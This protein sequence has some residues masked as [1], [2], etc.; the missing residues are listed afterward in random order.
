MKILALLCSFTLA[1]TVA[2]AR[3]QE[4]ETP[5]SEQSAAPFS[6]P[7]TE[8]SPAKSPASSDEKAY[9]TPGSASKAK[10]SASP[11][12]S[13]AAK[14]TPNKSTSSTAKPAATPLVLKGSADSQLRQIEDAY[15]AG[16][17]AHNATNVE[18][19][20]ANDAVLTDSKN[21]V[22]NRSAAIAEFK[23]S[24]DTLTTAKNSDMKV[25]MID[26]DVAVVTGVSHE[27]GKDKSGKAFDRR[28]RFTDTFVNRNGKW[29]VVA[30]HASVLSSR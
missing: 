8:S 4:T 2:V 25:H 23:S 21:R 26:K 30:S 29:L 18:P 20:I 12:A 14:P 11:S 5:T 3:G 1:L 17:Q 10:S 16:F 24:T 9:P 19:F 7:T 27:A 15:E 28:Y 6:E 13:P 22:M